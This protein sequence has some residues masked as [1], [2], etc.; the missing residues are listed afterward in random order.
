MIGRIGSPFSSTG[1]RTNGGR[2]EK[3]GLTVGGAEA[4][5][6]GSVRP[7]AAEITSCVESAEGCAR[8][9]SAESELETGR[10]VCSLG[11]AGEVAE[12]GAGDG[13]GGTATGRSAGRVTFP[14]RLKFDKSLGPTSVGGVSGVPLV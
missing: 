10:L 6:V 3:P 1:G 7:G 5:R 2:V 9:F 14:C 13:A 8:T 12:G 4:R 11:G